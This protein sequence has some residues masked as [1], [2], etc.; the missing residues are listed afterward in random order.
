MKKAHLLL[1]EDDENLGF[2]TKDNLEEKGYTVEWAKDG[3][4]GYERFYA[5]KYDLCIF[6]VMLPKKDGFTLAREIK[7]TNP[8]MPFFFLTAKTLQDDK[9]EGLTIGADDYITKPF[10]MEELVLRI[11]NMLTRLHG[12]DHDTDKKIFHLGSVEFDTQNHTLTR[13]E[14][15]ETLTKKESELL[16]LLCINQN[17]VLE[18]NTALRI[19][20]GDDD[21][22]LGRS[23]DVFITKLRK[24]LKGE[25]SITIENV[26]GIGFKLVVPEN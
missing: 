16:R 10:D 23:M 25:E 13:D 20:W 1:V 17:R 6:D 18:R 2:V 4:E 3:Q 7:D 15:T 5:D 24:R 26:H 9:I 12:S 14:E 19:I 11:D 21:Y 8:E 22:F